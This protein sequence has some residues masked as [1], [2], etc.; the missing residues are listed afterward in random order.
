MQFH[1]KLKSRFDSAEI[2]LGMTLALDDT[3]ASGAGKTT[4]TDH[5]PGIA[6]LPWETNSEMGMKAWGVCQGVL[7]RSTRG[8]GQKEAG[9]GRHAA[10]KSAL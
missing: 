8:G 9:S 5:G 6:W 10:V 1:A 7:C 3:V 2:Q 4:L